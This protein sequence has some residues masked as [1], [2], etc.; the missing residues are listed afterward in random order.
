[1]QSSDK[2]VKRR[3]LLS[4]ILVKYATSSLHDLHHISYPEVPNSLDD[5]VK[6]SNMTTVE[7]PIGAKV[8]VSAGEGYI[9]WVGSNPKFSAG[10]WVGIELC[11][12]KSI[13]SF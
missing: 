9:R 1:M 8:L 10:K 11:V 13:K 2:E 7:V 12:I 5:H 3:Q 6:T 4:P